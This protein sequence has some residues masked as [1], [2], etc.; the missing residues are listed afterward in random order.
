MN[1]INERAFLYIVRSLKDIGYGRMMQI[2]SHEW[3]RHDPI[4]AA[5]ANT[6]Y[7]LLNKK[8]R[9]AYETL[10]HNDPLFKD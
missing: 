3:F 1:E 8:E 10:A 6:C 5:L 2:I 7:G 9:I 4:G